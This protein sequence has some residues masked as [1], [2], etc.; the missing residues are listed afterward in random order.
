MKQRGGIVTIITLFLAA[1]FGV[2]YLPKRA[3]NTN[4][5]TRAKSPAA[6]ASTATPKVAPTGAQ[7]LLPA[8]TEIRRHLERFYGGPDVPVPEEAHCCADHAKKE[9]CISAPIIPPRVSVAIAIVPNPVQTHLPLL[10]DRLIEAIQQAVQDTGFNFDSAWFPWNPSDKSAQSQSE[11]QQSA[12]LKAETQ[13]QPGIIVF[14]HRADAKESP[15]PY[16][17][18]LVVLV[19]TE[20]PTGGVN[21]VEFQHAVAWAHA[22]DC[23]QL[24]IVGPTFSG[25]L[26]SLQRE[27][28]GDTLSWFPDGVNIFSGS[29]NGD[30]NII[31]F[32]AF[33]AKTKSPATQFR[34]F[35]ESDSL[36]IDRFLRYMQRDGYDLSS[37]AI[38]SEDETAF[39]ST[40][41]SPTDGNAS[42]SKP[43]RLYYPRD[44]ANLRSAYEQQ[45]IFSAGKQPSSG[46]T[47]SL[48][49]CAALA[50]PQVTSWRRCLPTSSPCSS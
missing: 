35:N 3:D 18:G 48:T 20:Q 19:V 6:A 15:D 26:P 10:F 1:L 49:G 14:R 12:D 28:T 7:E 13:S 38:L 27:L 9:N 37:F 47:G 22:L 45:S 46:P 41:S 30:D 11:A 8:C 32:K 39:G 2:S 24:R 25:T 17:M 40:N 4:A 21:D 42:E 34:T 36:M 50:S 33:L 23:C 16:D 5:D 44:I 31:A 29:T 43:L